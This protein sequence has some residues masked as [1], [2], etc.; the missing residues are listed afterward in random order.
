MRWELLVV[1]AAALV[2]SVAGADWTDCST[3]L[4]RLRRASRDAQAA[5]DEVASAAEEF[6][7][8]TN[9]LDQ[10]KSYPEL[11]DFMS[12]GCRTARFDAES[13]ASDLE[14]ERANLA[15]YLD[16]VSRRARDVNTSC[17]ADVEIEVE[18]QGASVQGQP[19]ICPAV[20][21]LAQRVSPEKFANFCSEALSLPECSRCL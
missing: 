9:E 4:D 3:D 2:A 20:R 18:H 15:S 5:A 8:A 13:A 11:Y 10:C 7:A 19:S 21:A 1:A 6:E 17:E 14:S 16:T 12:D